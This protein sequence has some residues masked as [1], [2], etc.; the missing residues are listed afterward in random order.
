MW[1]P[2]RS[3]AGVMWPSAS[4]L[5]LSCWD[6]GD[7][8]AVA[9]GDWSV[10]NQSNYWGS[11]CVRLILSVVP[12]VRFCPWSL[13]R[14]IREVMGN[15]LDWAFGVSC[16]AYGWVNWILRWLPLGCLYWDDEQ[17][18][19]DE[20]L[21][22]R[23]CDDCDAEL[24]QDLWGRLDLGER[25][26]VAALVG[27]AR[28]RRRRRLRTTFFLSRM[29][30]QKLRRMQRKIRP[31][32]RKLRGDTAKLRTKHL[33]R[34]V[35]VPCT[36]QANQGGD[37]DLSSRWR[38]RTRQMRRS[39]EKMFA[40]NFQ[41]G[42]LRGPP[43]GGSWAHFFWDGMNATDSLNLPE[44]LGDFQTEMELWCNT[45]DNSG[46]ISRER[47]VPPLKDRQQELPTPLSKL[48][49]LRTVSSWVRNLLEEGVEPN[50][51]PVSR[52]ERRKK[53]KAR[54]QVSGAQLMLLVSLVRSLLPVEQQGLVDQYCKANSIVLPIAAKQTGPPPKLVTK[55]N[56]TPNQPKAKSPGA[57]APEEGSSA[58][59]RGKKGKQE[60]D[61]QKPTYAEKAKAL[62]AEA[63]KQAKQQ[64]VKEAM[65]TWKARSEDFSQSVVPLDELMT[66]V[67]GLITAESTDQ[68]ASCVQVQDEEEL[69]QV[70]YLATA[71]PHSHFLT[72]RPLEEGDEPKEGEEVQHLPGR[73]LGRAITRVRRVAIH[74]TDEEAPRL[75]RVKK[76]SAVSITA[77]PTIVFKVAAEEQY[78]K[79]AWKAMLAKRGGAARQWASSF[80]TREEA[81]KLG[82]TFNFFDNGKDGN[83]KTRQWGMIRVDIGIAL[84]L[85]KHSGQKS[86]G[87]IRYFLE[88]WWGKDTMPQKPKC[89]YKSV[90]KSE[91]PSPEEYADDVYSRCGPLGAALGEGAVGTRAERTAEDDRG[92]KCWRMEAVPASYRFSDISALFAEQGMD[93]IVF[94]EHGPM[95]RPEDSRVPRK[96]WH[97]RAE[98]EPA[99]TSFEVV[100]SAGG[101][102]MTILAY[103]DNWAANFR[104]KKDTSRKQLPERVVRA[105]T[106]AKA[107][108]A[109]PPPPARPPAAAQAPMEVEGTG[110]DKDK[111]TKDPKD[112]PPDGV[113]AEAAASSASSEAAKRAAPEGAQQSDAR[114]RKVGEEPPKGLKLVRNPGLGNCGPAW[115]AQAISKATGDKWTTTQIRTKVS[116]HLK[117]YADDPVCR[118]RQR[119][120]E[121]GCP[122]PTEKEEKMEGSFED[123]CTAVG[124]PKAWVDFLWHYAAAAAFD[125]PI[126]IYTPKAEVQVFRRQSKKTPLKCWY[127][128]SHY[129]WLDGSEFEEDISAWV[130]AV[131]KGGKGG[132]KEGGS[133]GTASSLAARNR[134]RKSS[135]GTAASL[136]SR[137]RKAVGSWRSASSLRN[138]GAAAAKAVER[139]DETEAPA[140]KRRRTWR[141]A[142]PIRSPPALVDAKSVKVK[143]GD[144]EEV[145]QLEVRLGK[146]LT[147]ER[148]RLMQQEQGRSVPLSTIR[149]R[150]V[151][152][153]TPQRDF[154]AVGAS[155]PSSSSKDPCPLPSARK[156]QGV[157]KRP[158]VTPSKNLAADFAICMPCR[159]GLRDDGSSSVGSMSFRTG[160]MCG[161]TASAGK[162]QQLRDVCEM[163]EEIPTGKRKLAKK[164]YWKCPYCPELY[165]GPRAKV[166]IT[167]SRHLKV[168][169]PVEK[170]NMEAFRQRMLELDVKVKGKSFSWKCPLCPKGIYGAATTHFNRQ[171]RQRH[172]AAAHPRANKSRFVCM[173]DRELCSKRTLER[174]AK[175][176]QQGEDG[177]KAIDERIRKYSLTRRAQQTSKLMVQAAA[178]EHQA[179]VVEAPLG[180][181]EGRLELWCSK[182]GKM[183]LSTKEMKK[184]EAL[185]PKQ[186]APTMSKVKRLK[187]AFK[188]REDSLTE[189]AKKRCLDYISKC[190]LAITNSRTLQ[191]TSQCEHK[192]VKFTGFCEADRRIGRVN[193]RRNWFPDT[194]YVCRVCLYKTRTAVEAKVRMQCSSSIT[195]VR[196]SWT[197]RWISDAK[198]TKQKAYLKLARWLGVRLKEKLKKQRTLESKKSFKATL[199]KANLAKL[200]EGNG[201]RF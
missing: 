171:R 142:K 53:K 111:D 114:R 7:L 16:W 176:K 91:F 132:A 81:L 29:M 178:S 188:S 190:S 38:T 2:N 27:G 56:D 69:D 127:N 150:F 61:P 116:A 145:R 120:T 104:K 71:Y 4:L 165:R 8:R 35:A 34:G 141:S 55:S 134:K 124:R 46:S 24:E 60:G 139:P 146:Q 18:R 138:R 70:K 39:H 119:W 169:H 62:A 32:K 106:P 23:G 57:T 43:G 184:C 73:V 185:T 153:M 130:N 22:G 131:P 164:A 3:G 74:R 47:R 105:P 66:K 59:Q 159:P 109:A 186:R 192:M 78:C 128:K 42:A 143:I 199:S 121:C 158:R 90:R 67:D 174:N 79:E 98:E 108:A 197:K 122:A 86:E 9:A 54:G 92:P 137:K 177:Q 113:G 101:E 65:A 102:E 107:E 201:R 191:A 167:K 63:K 112:A 80:L 26:A 10:S 6:P 103:R 89:D 115:L 40:L 123:Y 52:A 96:F 14:K 195:K 28:R 30:I 149:D 136:V 157:D 95:P 162:A 51:G 187:E 148:I 144:D 110:G 166:S 44:N 13:P 33:G 77:D 19:E 94:S 181:M 82:D 5:F 168:E 48:N 36:A 180:Y 76:K 179:Q 147:P 15:G 87:K 163:A 194:T 72:I 196:A 88:P 75:L 1:V 99:L 37:R 45:T 156:S 117:K 173:I 21:D 83:P 189:E 12:T 129:E 84:K 31:W 125:V 25:R 118:Y 135:W 151:D 11:V 58:T 97:V 170:A 175:L 172:A 160:K 41:R 20:Q 49:L 100:V 85:L 64:E 154:S 17:P 183:G 140:H 198:K 200:T 68:V 155:P 133:W 152:V 50:P 126:A 161:S 93:N 182:C 193:T